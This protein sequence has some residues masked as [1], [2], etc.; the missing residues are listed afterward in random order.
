MTYPGKF[1]DKRADNLSFQFQNRRLLSEYVNNHSN[2]VQFS[3]IS[4][5]STDEHSVGVT[6]NAQHYI[7]LHYVIIYI[8]IYRR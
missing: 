5:R 7:I 3:A 2:F 1:E 4:A 8:Y 6:D